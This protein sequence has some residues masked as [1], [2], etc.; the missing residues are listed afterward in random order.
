M[1]SSTSND[2]GLRWCHNQHVLGLRWHW[3]LG[4]S[5]AC[6]IDQ[7]IV[8]DS[9]IGG[10]IHDHLEW[11]HVI[12]HWVVWDLGI[13]IQMILLWIE[14]DYLRANNLWARGFVISIYI[15][16]YIWIWSKWMESSHGI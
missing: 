11:R 6:R 12:T 8:L 4:E 14:I 5:I 15:Y 9:G 16:I 2:G 1:T 13:S 7:R 3:D 10:S